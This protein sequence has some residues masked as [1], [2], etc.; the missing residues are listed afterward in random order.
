MVFTEHGFEHHD[1]CTQTQECA[2]CKQETCAKLTDLQHEITGTDSLPTPVIDYVIAHFEEGDREAALLTTTELQRQ[3]PNLFNVPADI[4]PSVLASMLDNPE[5]ATLDAQEKSIDRENADLDQEIEAERKANELRRTTVEVLSDELQ[6]EEIARTD[7]S[8]KD[9]SGRTLINA[10]YRLGFVRER[11]ALQDRLTMISEKLGA[12]QGVA[13]SP[14]EAEALDTIIG[15]SALYFGAGNP[16][17]VFADVLART[18]S[19]P[20][21]SEATK[22]KVHELFNIPTVK[23]AADI[24]MVLNQGYGIGEDGKRLPFTKNNKARVFDNTYVYETPTGER[25]FEV[26][27]PDGRNLNIAFDGETNTQTLGNLIYTTQIIFEMEKMSLAEPIFQRGWNITH[28]GNI[29]LHF[30]DIMT[31]KRIGVMFLGGTAGYDTELLSGGDQSRMSHNFQAF[32]RKGD[33]AHADNNSERA[34]T[35]YQELTII[36]EDGTINWSRFEKAALYLQGVTARGGQPNFEDLK[37]YLTGG[38]EMEA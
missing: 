14:A 16:A 32:P 33:A 30:D 2:D 22:A 35:E 38:E 3:N 10:L 34:L 28:G 5:N 13:A 29:D 26:K 27:L 36:N 25:R 15:Q 4:M 12:I 19:D 11:P 18:D 17:D 23:T 8:L 37:T 6:L 20:N 24:Q 21:I 1:D 7:P 9:L 31:A